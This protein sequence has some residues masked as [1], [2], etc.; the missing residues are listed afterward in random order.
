MKYIFGALLFAWASAEEIINSSMDLMGTGCILIALCLFIMKERFLNKALYTGIFA[1]AVIGFSFE[2]RYLLVLLGIVFVDT[3]Y[4][5]R[6]D[7]LAAAAIIAGVFY[8][9]TG[10]LQ[11]SFHCSVGVLWGYTLQKNEDKE[12]AHIALL[13]NER[14]LRYQLE[15]AKNGLEALQS[16]IERTAQIRERD[17]IAKQIHDNVGHNIAGV[18]FQLQA[19]E[20]LV[21]TNSQKVG[22][23]LRLCVEKL[24][25]ALEITRNTVYDI[26]S[27]EMIGIESLHNIIKDFKFCKI[28]FIHNGD[29]NS[30]SVTNLKVLE[31]TVK[32]LLTNAIKHSAASEIILQID[33]KSRYIRCFYKDNGKGCA[34]IKENV[35]LNGIR[36]RIKNLGGTYSVDGSSGF[37]VVC[38]LP[39]GREEEI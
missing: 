16:E 15:K 5:K 3:A 22:E 20:R 31:T 32:E 9:R 39:N 4:F 30:I 1:A 34:R 14:A 29:F 36:E 7:F 19:A 33:I 37:T 25:E 10:M 26:K 17:R 13:D 2:S 28:S 23:I 24:A 35:G 18:L 27:N 38:T 12:K 6:Y 8:Y 21:V 11:Y